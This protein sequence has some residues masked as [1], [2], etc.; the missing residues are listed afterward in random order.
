MMARKTA[1]K[2]KRKTAPKRKGTKKKAVKKKTAKRKAA[3][4]KAARKKTV[5]KKAV[6]KKVGK[7]IAKKRT[8][9][10]KSAKKKPA[11][12]KAAKKK[13]AKKKRA[14][15]KKVAKKKSAK[16]KA[17]GKKTA[18][19]K[20]SKKPAKKKAAKKKPA[21][22][23]KTAKKKTARKKVVR[24]KPGTAPSPIHWPSPVRSTLLAEPA[25]TAAPSKPEPPRPVEP[26]SAPPP[27]ETT[28]P[29]PAPPP[30]DTGEELNVAGIGEEAV[31]NATGKGWEEWFEILERAGAPDIGHQNMARH[32]AETHGLTG[33]WSQ[34]VTVGYERA[35]GGRK[36][37]ETAEGFSISRSLTLDVPVERMFAA[38]NDASI[39]DRWLGE[40][41]ITVTTVTEPRSM[42]ILWKDGRTRLSVDF[43]PKG[44]RRS[45]V[46]VQHMKLA[47]EAEAERMKEYWGRALVSLQEVLSAGGA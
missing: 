15:K 33:W 23:K 46:T 34:M 44:H 7:K 42:R 47:D 35:R 24:R 37:H 18:K 4:K 22:R 1:K 5:K 8:G 3:K 36:K 12:K 28:A 39:R 45:L 41:G 25:A 31:R 40:P 26:V 13:V 29:A 38:W 32:L 30:P 16:K 27:P 11:K 43:Y 10:K 17:A 6:R 21:T 2:A 9:K 20:A 14:G 19:K